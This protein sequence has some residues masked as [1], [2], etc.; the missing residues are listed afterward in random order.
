M[1]IFSGFFVF[2]GLLI[3]GS[4]LYSLSKKRRTLNWSLTYAEI[5]SSEVIHI[6]EDGFHPA[7]QIYYRYLIDK[8]YYT[9]NTYQ[10]DR[11]YKLQEATDISKQHKVGVKIP[12]YYDKNNPST[13]VIIRG[14]NGYENNVILLGII[15]TIAGAYGMYIL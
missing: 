2:M 12:I 9:G 14:Y 13:S 6:D 15:S 3:I 10:L 1:F 11:A 4:S 7:P 5:L 8:V